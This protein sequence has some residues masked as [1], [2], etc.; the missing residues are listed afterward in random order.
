MAHGGRWG[1]ANLEVC[2]AVL[3]SAQE[4]RKVLLSH[5]NAGSLIGQQP[6]SRCRELSQPH[7]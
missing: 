2:L 4:R 1:K 6:G 5:G 7:D 3:A